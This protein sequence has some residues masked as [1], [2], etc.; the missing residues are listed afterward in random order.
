MSSGSTASPAR[1]WAELV[2]YCTYDSHVHTARDALSELRD[3]DLGYSP[4]PEVALDWDANWRWPCVQTPRRLLAH[5][6][7]A[8]RHY[9]N[10]LVGEKGAERSREW[11]P[12][13]LADAMGSAQGL[14]ARLE[15]TLAL[16]CEGVVGLTDEGLL[17]PAC[18]TW[19]GTRVK[20]FVV[21]D[22]AI[23]HVAWHLGQIA[24]LV[25]WHR[26]QADG[27][28][29]APPAGPPGPFAYPGERDWSAFG[30]G[31]RT[32]ALL[33]LSEAA[34]RESPWHPLRRVVEGMTQHELAWRPFPDIE[35]PWF[36]RA[37]WTLVLHT[38]SPKIVYID[39]AFGER[40]LDYGP[41]S[42][43]I[44]GCGWGETDPT[45]EL[46]ALDRA[47]QWL[48]E[49]VSRAT[50][51]DLDRVNPMHINHP[52]TGWQVVAC[53]AQHDAWHAGQLSLMRDLYA[54]LWNMR[55]P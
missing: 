25:D 4:I 9:A 42:D 31:T 18:E 5:L 6:T 13:N 55:Q 2:R 23:L 41:S 34:F 48:M 3:E 35:N 53:M 16:L 36:C 51:E 49:H 32:E 28:R 27:Q 10:G 44:A 50:D 33:R 20:G 47:Q 22:G 7:F 19:D 8:A 45:K 12:A 39:H 46:T 37:M 30:V 43:A 17:E 54:A 11:I 38:W 26:A 29:L 1:L 24:M 15:Q 40:T 52:M 21:M 14:V